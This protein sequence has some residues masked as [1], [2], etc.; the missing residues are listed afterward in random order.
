MLNIMMAVKFSILVQGRYPFYL[1]ALEATFIQTSYPA[2][3]QQKEFVYSLK[4]VH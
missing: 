2:L 1:S 3:G 4:I